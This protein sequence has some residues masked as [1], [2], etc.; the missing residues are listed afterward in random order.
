MNKHI[1]AAAFAC[2]LAATIIPPAQANE[3]RFDAGYL[4]SK[5]SEYRSDFLTLKFYL[6]PVST[7]NIPLAEADFFHR[8]SSL[9]GTVARAS[10]SSEATN[11]YADSDYLS[12]AYKYETSLSPVSIAVDYSYANSDINSGNGDVSADTSQYSMTF[13]YRIMD[14]LTASINY[15]HSESKY[16]S[17]FIDSESD[18]KTAQVKYV[19]LMQ[20]QHALAITGYYYANEFVAGNFKQKSKFFS[21]DVTYYINHR[22]GIS[23]GYSD[24]SSNDQYDEHKIYLLGVSYFINDQLYT[25][26]QLTE[27]QF[28]TFNP[29]Y[30]NEPQKY[31]TTYLGINYRF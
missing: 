9:L 4:Y 15:S 29:S 7:E 5:S 8:G 12:L 18:R 14:S 2:L 10:T 23:L 1:K 19:Y 26:L 30:Y 11:F 3:Y 31:T 28:N 22:L 17:S 16:D 27:T 20:N 6:N 24:Y 13:G 21:L 25:T